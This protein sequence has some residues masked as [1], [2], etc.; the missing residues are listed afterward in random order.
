MRAGQHA[1]V[2]EYG[3]DHRRH[4]QG[5]G[6]DRAQKQQPAQETDTG[7]AE[8]NTET[9]QHESRPFHEEEHHTHAATIQ[10]YP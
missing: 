8:D 10:E 2:V 6:I 4:E 3:G 5:R 1:M 7:E 9:E